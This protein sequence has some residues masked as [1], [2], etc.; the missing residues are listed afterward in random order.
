MQRGDQ[1]VGRKPEGGA[2]KLH[3]RIQQGLAGGDLFTRQG[4][5]QGLAEAQQHPLAE[6]LTAETEHHGGFAA[7]G[8][9]GADQQRVGH[10]S[11]C[12]SPQIRQRRCHSL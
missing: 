12:G 4:G 11:S 6:Q 2:H 10:G 7:E 1:A 3:I 8:F 9:T 5:G